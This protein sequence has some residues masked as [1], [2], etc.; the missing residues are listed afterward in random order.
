MPRHSL[1]VSL[2]AEV[3]GRR[4]QTAELEAPTMFVTHFSGVSH[5]NDFSLAK[6]TPG[7]DAY[8]WQFVRNYRLARCKHSE[9]PPPPFSSC[10]FLAFPGSV[11]LLFCMH[12][13]ALSR[14]PSLLDSSCRISGN[15]CFCCHSKGSA[16][17]A[18]A[19]LCTLPGGEP[20]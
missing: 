11:V 17:A 3:L 16:T 6:D 10:I 7:W 13:L 14:S 9:V 15:H 1:G 5:C 19:A 2:E 4:P 8:N 12:V 18:A 20:L